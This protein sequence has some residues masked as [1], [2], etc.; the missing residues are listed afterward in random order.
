M[1][2][3]EG[4]LI[5]GTLF[6]IFLGGRVSPCIYYTLPLITEISSRGHVFQYLVWMN[7]ALDSLK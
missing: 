3:I 6:S 7:F 5:H 4:Y 2:K 1:V